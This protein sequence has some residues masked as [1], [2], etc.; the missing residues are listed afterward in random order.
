MQLLLFVLACWL[1]LYSGCNCFLFRNASQLLPL[2]DSQHW[3]SLSFFMEKE[4]WR[5][6]EGGNYCQVNNLEPH[7]HCYIFFYSYLSSS[8]KYTH[9]FSPEKRVKSPIIH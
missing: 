2:H 4:K 8:S 6:W 1:C 7:C 5:Q 3:W 9:F